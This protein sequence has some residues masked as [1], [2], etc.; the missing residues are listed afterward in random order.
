MTV[1]KNSL[2]H[3]EELYDFIG[4]NNL[5]CN[6]RPAFKCDISNLDYMTNDDYF[7]FFKKLFIIWINDKE[8]I[9]KL[10][11]IKEIYDEF[12]KTL[13]SSYNNKSEYPN[14]ISAI[15]SNNTLP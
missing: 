11:Q 12:A 13:K 14:T 5:K 1:T 2:G 15:K 3:E 10:T 6:I 9:V 4:K 8:K 7:E